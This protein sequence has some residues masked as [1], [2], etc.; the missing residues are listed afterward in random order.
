VP[1]LL[2]VGRKEAADR[3]VSIRRLGKEGQTVLPLDKALAALAEE[4]VPPDLRRLMQAAGIVRKLGEIEIDVRL[5]SLGQIHDAIDHLHK[6]DFV[7]AITLASAAEGILPHTDKPHLFPKLKAL[8]ASLPADPEGATGV[9]AFTNWTKHGT[10]Q[11]ATISELEVIA[12]ILRAISKFGAVYAEQS[13]QMKEFSEWA[14]ARL[15]AD[16]N[17]N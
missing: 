5:A 7:S 9:N 12:T 17:S 6:S 16:K 4:A 8:S 3:T 2:V 13:P 14:T 10:H 11:K 15:G 1:A